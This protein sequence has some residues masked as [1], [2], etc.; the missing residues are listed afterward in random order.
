MFAGITTMNHEN[1]GDSLI[2]MFS[3]EGEY[4]TF[5]KNVIISED[6]IIYVWLSKIE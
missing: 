6:P 3:K 1:E 2:G 4:V 5:N